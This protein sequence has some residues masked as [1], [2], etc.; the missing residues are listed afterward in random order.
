MERSMR[1]LLSC[2][3][4]AIG[5]TEN[6]PKPY[7]DLLPFDIGGAVYHT[8]YHSKKS[9]GAASYLIV[10]EEGNILVDSPRFV[11]SLAEK[12]ESLGGIA[13]IFLT[14]KDD[15]AD[16]AKFAK[17]FGAKR[18]LHKD[19]MT[20]DTKEIEMLI[21][22]EGDIDLAP[23]IKIIPVPGHTKGSCCLLYDDRYLFTGDHLYQNPGRTFPTAFI[24]HCWYSWERQ[25][26]S[27]EKLESYRFEQ[28]VPGHG[29]GVRYGADIMPGKIAECVEWMK[30]VVK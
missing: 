24:N 13:Y 26:E 9:F 30:S 21:E 14:H 15:V 18:I 1:A 5:T 2:P 7:A 3:V 27:M 28:I 8:G 22:G 16:H 25:T 20:D 10:R 29:A 4:S 17:R 11:G 6:D 23:D 19:D 12:I